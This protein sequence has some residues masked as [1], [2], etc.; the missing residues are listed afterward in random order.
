LAFG[1]PQMIYIHQ[2]F[3]KVYVYQSILTLTAYRD[4]I[5]GAASVKHKNI[6]VCI[7]TTQHFHI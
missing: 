2:S 7:I 5:E 3:L 6:I 1:N 4:R